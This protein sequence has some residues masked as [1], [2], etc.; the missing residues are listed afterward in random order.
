MFVTVP[1]K[2]ASVVLRKQVGYN[3]AEV[4]KK[5]FTLFNAVYH[6]P[7]KHGEIRLERISSAIFKCLV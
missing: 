5:P 1:R 3:S 6:T 4:F 7:R 2:A